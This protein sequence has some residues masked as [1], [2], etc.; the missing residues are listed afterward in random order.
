MND[1]NTLA[2]LFRRKPTGYTPLVPILRRVFALPATPAGHDK[3]QVVIVLTDGGPTD[4]NDEEN[5]PQLCEMLQDKRRSSTTYV[6]FGLCNDDKSY[7]NELRS[8]TQYMAHV[9]VTD[10]YEDELQWIRQ[11]CG[12]HS[13]FPY[14]A[15]I[16]KLILG[17]PYQ[18]TPFH[19]Q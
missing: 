1:L 18:N 16:A 3:K 9:A 5:I 15:F 19:E 4:E 17:P 7:I 6:S 12:P 11:N 2:Q 14:G 10:Q 13:R 8:W